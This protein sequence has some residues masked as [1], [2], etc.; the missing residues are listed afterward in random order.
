[1]KKTA[2]VILAV[3]LVGIVAAAGC[4]ST[5]TQSPEGYWTLP[6]T[7][8]IMTIT[9]EGSVLG[10]A[11]VNLFSG[12]CEVDGD[13]LTFNL[14]STLM[15]GSEDDG[16]FF[17]AINSVDSFKIVDGKLVL[18]SEGKEVLTF[19]KAV[20]GTWTTE[21]GIVI[22]FNRDMTFGG[23]G[24][25]NSFSGSYAYTENGIEFSNVISTMAF[26]SEE[27]MA[28]ESAFFAVL[29]NPQTLSVDNGK[30]TLGKLTLTA[31]VVGEWVTF[32]GIDLSLAEDGSVS[33]KAQVN[34]FMG[35]FEEAD[36]KITFKN[37]VSTKMMGAP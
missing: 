12:F 9:P 11:P 15:T 5:E 19:S 23:H 37:I 31:S 32:D 18:M 21:D 26:G 30:L 34:T 25:V 8:V 27:D 20:L 28:V 1:M 24:P 10:K 3:A 17:A 22:T 16:P 2:F 6:G 4:I 13:K 35:E 33:G 7:D 36:G 14:A 29:A